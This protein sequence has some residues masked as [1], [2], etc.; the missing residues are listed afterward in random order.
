MV[1]IRAP[2]LLV[3]AALAAFCRPSSYSADAFQPRVHRNVHRTLRAQGTVDLI[4]SFKDSTESVLESV[5]EA[6]FTTRGTKIANLVDRLE[7]HAST[8]QTSLNDVLDRT[9]R[10]LQIGGDDDNAPPPQLLYESKTSLWISNQVFIKAA[11]FELVEL[12][13]SLE[14]VS[15]IQEDVSFPLSTAASSSAAANSS[16]LETATRNTWEINMI[17][18]PGVWAKGYTGQGVVVGTIDSGVFGDHSDLKKNFRADH[19][20]LDPFT[21]ASFPEDAT[22]HGTHVMGTIAGANGIGVAPRAKW[23]ACRA[24]YEFCNYSAILMCTQFMMCPTDP[25]S[26]NQDCSKAAHVVSNSWGSGQGD[27]AFQASA[28]AWHAAE[29]IPVFS[30]GNDGPACGTAHSPGDLRE[31]I[32]VGGTNGNDDQYTLTGKGPA[33][34][35]AMKP[36]ISAPGQGIRSADITGVDAYAIKSGTSFAAPHVAGVVALLLSVRPGL[37]YDEVKSTLFSTAEW[38]WLGATEYTCG[39]TADSTFPNNQYG[40]GRVEALAAVELLLGVTPTPAPTPAPTQ[41]RK[42]QI[43]V[44]AKAKA[45]VASSCAPGMAQAA[46]AA[47]G[48]KPSA[49]PLECVSLVE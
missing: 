30:I 7:A 12:L 8:S 36:D 44:L 48:C 34:N 32:G 35:G 45:F 25:D 3:I 19:G 27:T 10:R 26:A 33:V 21:L 14:S 29:I 11:T 5:K 18:A 22:G 40:H 24:C 31:V 9:R 6:E 28:N 13:S 15:A 46:R 41:S 17:G 47:R 23:I 43:G 49:P 1:S 4:V 16:N 20:W 39:G 37:T 38:S 42:F 2:S